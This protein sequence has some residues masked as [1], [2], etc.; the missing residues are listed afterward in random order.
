MQFPK[1]DIDKIDCSVSPTSTLRDGTYSF[2]VKS[3]ADHIS[4]SGNPCIKLTLQCEDD[5][6]N[7][8]LVFDYLTMSALWKFKQLA[9]S[10]G[11][12]SLCVS[13]GHIDPSSFLNQQG[14]VEIVVQASEGYAP[15]PK[16]KFYRPGEKEVAFSP[17]SPV[18]SNG[19]DL[20]NPLD[21]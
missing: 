8:G 16:V 1:F 13:E 17:L 12:S 3:A 19:F 14:M 15:S 18:D 7:R 20:D 6:G 11:D 2:T 5:D 9:I 4:Q 21:I 10:V